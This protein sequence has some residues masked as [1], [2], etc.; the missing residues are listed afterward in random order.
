ML[1]WGVFYFIFLFFHRRCSTHKTSWEH[2]SLILPST[3]DFLESS[4]TQVWNIWHYCIKLSVWNIMIH[5]RNFAFCICRG[6]LKKKQHYYCEWGM[7][8]LPSPFIQQSFAICNVLTERISVLFII[9]I[10]IVFN[11]YLSGKCLSFSLSGTDNNP[12]IIVTN[13]DSDTSSLGICRCWVPVWQQV[14][15]FHRFK[16][17]NLTH[18]QCFI[19][20]RPHYLC[21]NC[22]CVHACF[23]ELMRKIGEMTCCCNTGWTS[24]GFLTCGATCNPT[25]FTT[26]VCWLS[27]WGSTK[28]L[29]RSAALMP[30]TLPASVCSCIIFLQ[31]VGKWL[32]SYLASWSIK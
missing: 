7:V 29:L 22:L 2:W 14:H 6:N 31:Q 5:L 12:C 11:F 17:F 20:I 10:I 27:R 13:A 28:S 4:I 9:I 15:L 3:W 32:C 24:G 30:C 26:S 19:W 23:Q 16:T 8:F 18:R 25:S 1:T 21:L